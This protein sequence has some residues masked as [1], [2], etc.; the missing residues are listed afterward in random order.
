[1]ASIQKEIKYLNTLIS[2]DTI[3]K[4]NK[5]KARKRLNEIELFLKT[6]D[7]L[8]NMPSD[9]S[10]GIMEHVVKTP[11]KLRN[12]TDHSSQYSM[13]S[14]PDL[15]LLSNFHRTPHH[16]IFDRE[17]PHGSYYQPKKD[18]ITGLYI[19]PYETIH[20]KSVNPDSTRES[21]MRVN[22]KKEQRGPDYGKKL[23]LKDLSPEKRRLLDSDRARLLGRNSN[24]YSKTYG[25]TRKKT[26][27]VYRKKYKKSK[28]KNRRRSRGRRSRRY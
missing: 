7:S 14:G 25:G 11:L 26:K 17:I 28:R 1:M 4:N 3:S 5:D 13:Y 21:L 22:K 18:P 24:T 6:Q 23:L 19:Y 8:L 15:N 12:I 10:Q 20:R 16:S 2:N 9:I 27:G